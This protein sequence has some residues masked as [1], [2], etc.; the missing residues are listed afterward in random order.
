MVKVAPVLLF[1]IRPDACYTAK[2]QFRYIYLKIWMLNLTVW[3]ILLGSKYNTSIPS[4]FPK[5]IMLQLRWL[6][7]ETIEDSQG[8]KHH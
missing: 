6:G 5:F 2:K 8:S 7:S 4:N 1:Q 3:G